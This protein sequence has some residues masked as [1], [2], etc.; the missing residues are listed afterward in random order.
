MPS[1]RQ[2]L[3]DLSNTQ[4]LTLTGPATGTP[5]SQLR[6]AR[7]LHETCFQELR[8]APGNTSL[9]SQSAIH[10]ITRFND[11]RYFAAGTVLY[12][13]G[14]SLITGLNGSPLTL[15]RIPPG[16]TQP[17][18]LFLA[19]GGVTRKI[20][21]AGT[22]RAWG[23]DPPPNGFTAIIQAQLTRDIE[24]FED[25]TTWTLVGTGVTRANEATIR[26]EGTNSLRLTIP[27]NTLCTVSKALVLNLAQFSVS[28]DSSDEDLIELWIR[29]DGATGFDY[30]T[31]R[32]DVGAGD[33]ASNFYQYKFLPTQ[34]TKNTRLV[35]GLG[36]NPT[37]TTDEAGFVGSSDGGGESSSGTVAD[38]SPSGYDNSGFADGVALSSATWTRLRVP[39]RA[40][41]RT[42]SNANTWANVV[43]LQLMI[44]TNTTQSIIV[45]LDRCRMI[46]GAG[47]LGDYKHLV[48]FDNTTTGA[49]SN[50]NPTFVTTQQNERQRVLYASLPVSADAQVTARTLW[51]TLGNGAAFF[52]EKIIADN[53]TTTY[54]SR[55]ADFVG[56]WSND[57]A[58][59]L[60]LPELPTDNARPE[61]THLDFLYDQATVFWLSAAASKK[62]RVYFSPAGR[63]EAQAG[64][65]QVTNDDMP[66]FRLIVWNRARYIIGEGGWWRIDG[67]SPYTSFKFQGVPG[68]L[69][70]QARTIVPTPYGILWQA[71]DGL[72][73]FNGSG[74]QLLHFERLGPLFRGEAAE[75]LTALQGTCAAFAREQ[76]FISDGAQTLSLNLSTGFI[77]D[78]G[79][80]FSALYYEEDTRLLLGG[81]ST[82]LVIV[83]DV[84]VPPT[85][86]QAWETAALYAPPGQTN[87][88]QRLYIDAVTQALPMTCTL[89]ID[90]VE[91]ALPPF[92]LAARGIIEYPLGIAY[93]SFGVRLTFTPTA[94]TRVYH[95]DADIYAST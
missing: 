2:A 48:T 23:I 69:S 8:P 52:R 72:R 87:T 28:G 58:E 9:F 78:L 41:L 51:R 43:A 49:R 88:I 85:V 82:G 44:V 14:V 26:E 16:N 53:T 86:P 50:S 11:V 77:R 12:R 67:T 7:G 15:T 91:R 64:F 57:N 61:D 35:E 20:D 36:A 55:V 29:V 33:F 74:S 1:R 65:I 45:Y 81:N 68:V 21:T 84:G 47:L 70:A 4:G 37:I 66:L 56:L 73:L 39:K 62:G 95:I 80:G 32:F 93:Q 24:L 34:I 3:L 27:A 90:S 5:P 46:G 71:Q 76:Y 79:Q 83:E 30:C 18:Q 40:F 6:R 59:V 22:V 13:A 63:P 25:Q 19:G 75:Q 89:L 54:N 10:S 38:P 94:G 31:L 60:Y 92:V 17:D 42:G